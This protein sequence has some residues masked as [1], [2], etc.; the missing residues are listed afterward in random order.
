MEKDRLIDLETPL[1]RQKEGYHTMAIEHFTAEYTLYPPAH[2][3][4]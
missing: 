3:F 2:S 1:I 4:D